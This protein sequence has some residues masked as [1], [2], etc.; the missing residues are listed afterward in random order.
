MDDASLTE[1]ISI[2]Q[3]DATGADFFGTQKGKNPANTVTDQDLALR[4]W[5]DEVSQ[6]AT[7]AEDRRMALSIARAIHSDRQLVTAAQDEEMRAAEDRR[8]AM[9]L[10]GRR[11]R[12][13]AVRAQAQDQAH[14]QYPPKAQAKTHDSQH[15]MVHLLV[16]W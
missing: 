8:L 16:D 15:G 4:A 2:L 9:R 11:Q 12:Q 13:A 6:Y 5:Q 3:C 1:I 14:V 7:L 10:A